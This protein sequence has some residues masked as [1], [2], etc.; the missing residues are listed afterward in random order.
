M[1][2][3]WHWSLS[4]SINSPGFGYFWLGCSLVSALVWAIFPSAGGW[5]LLAAGLPWVA[6]TLSGRWKFRP[7]WYDLAIAIFV[8]TAALGVWASYDPIAAWVK[9][10]RIL[11][12]VQLFYAIARQP[13]SHLQ[14]LAWIFSGVSGA[15]ATYFLFSYNWT[16]YPVR[17]WKVNSLGEA[18]M[19]FRPEL[20]LPILNAD[21]AGTTIAM[22]LPLNLA[23]GL[24]AWASG[25]KKALT[26]AVALGTLSGLGLFLAVERGAW[27]GLAAGLA[28]WGWRWVCRAIASRFRLPEWPVFFG[29]ILVALLA[30]LILVRF[31]PDFLAYPIGRLTAND[32]IEGLINNLNLMS[33]YPWIGGGLAAFS[34]LYSRYI[35]GI[36]YVF[37]ENSHNLY[38]SIGIEQ[39]WFGLASFL[40]LWAIS[41]FH[42][43]TA[44]A[45]TE[46]FDS[47]LRWSLITGY[48]TVLLHALTEDAFHAEIGMVG[49]FILPGFALAF[50]HS[51]PP[52]PLALPGWL[53][54]WMAR[55]ATKKWIGIAF[56]AG[57]LGLVMLNTQSLVSS[58]YANLGA[59]KMAQVHLAGWPEQRLDSDQF[60]IAVEPCEK[61]LEQAV[62]WNLDNPIAHYRAGL[63]DLERRD[64]QAAS[65]HLE[66]AYAIRP[67]HCGIKKALGY[68]RL[69]LNDLDGAQP[70]LETVPEAIKELGSYAHWWKTQNRL[71]LS[72][73]AREMLTRLQN[74]Y[75]EK[76]R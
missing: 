39:G 17:L 26:G 54:A 6:Q 9:F 7:S 67:S 24:A 53:T 5:P 16:H 52:S 34:G 10:W 4:K 35:L 70:L 74:Q 32:R 68:T 46:R 44:E 21:V 43:R 37:I 58:W 75:N 55:R 11:A 12:A 2:T 61:F 30:G 49:L 20:G 14:G 48:T 73:Q 22:L 50:I 29:A 63:V 8:L 62:T 51:V 65:Q 19:Q 45:P 13:A 47:L 57:V 76:E 18:W 59:V 27:F 69:W 23:V 15:V 40:A 60:L 72:N 71:D 42:L 41:L 31:P 1:A 33:A 56:A 38:L 28:L 36:H 66:R 25:N 3:Q 64:F